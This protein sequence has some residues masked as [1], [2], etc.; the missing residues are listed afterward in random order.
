MGL[1]P[2]QL[3]IFRQD[4]RNGKK[5]DM[6]HFAVYKPVLMLEIYEIIDFVVLSISWNRKLMVTMMRQKRM[7]TK[8]LKMERYA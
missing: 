2:H 1:F 5:S 3:F 7:K 6:I 4:E 8:S